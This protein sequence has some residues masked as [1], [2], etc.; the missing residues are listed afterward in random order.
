MGLKRRG[1]TDV[2]AGFQHMRVAGR[3]LTIW[4]KYLIVESVHHY[5]PEPVMNRFIEQRAGDY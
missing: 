2:S 1:L 4:K 5:D 3:P